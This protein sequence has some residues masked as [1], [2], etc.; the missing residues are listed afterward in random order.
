MASTLTIAEIID[1]ARDFHPSF[2]EKRQPSKAAMR[3]I[4]RAE[5]RIA[6]RVTNINE[7]ALAE[8]VTFRNLEVA[9]MRGLDL[10][11]HIIILETTY[12][13]GG[14]MRP[15]PLVVYTDWMTEGLRRFPSAY[16][17]GNRM[18][19]V[20]RTLVGETNT[21]WEDVDLIKVVLVKL[22]PFHKSVD[23]TI[24][25]PDVAHDALVS[26]LAHWMALRT[27]GLDSSQL[28]GQAGAAENVL[29][30]TLASRGATS[31]WQVRVTHYP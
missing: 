30:D 2:D 21:G 3:Q 28:Y 31:S 14:V 17:L 4:T 6:E 9:L 11:E 16:L 1:E 15:V 24:A 29:V 27:P 5:R 12:E 13:M 22:P 19:P 10:P 25:L 23:E 26:N 20:N 8:E 7:T 18:Y